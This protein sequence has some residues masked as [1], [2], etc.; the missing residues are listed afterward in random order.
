MT[1]A[2]AASDDGYLQGRLLIA[3][4]VIGDPRFDRSVVFM[5]AHGEDHAMGI[6]VNRPMGRLRLPELFEQLEVKCE[7]Q[8]PDRAVL[9]G[10]PVDRDRGFVL[11]SDDFRSDEGTLPVGEGIGLTATKEI[12]EAMASSR[13]P[14]RSTLAL[15]YA[16]WE[17]GQL[18]EEI[19]ANAWLVAEAD[20]ELV[21]GEDYDAKWTKALRKLGVTPEF[22]T[23]A[24][25]RA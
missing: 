22:L 17:A 8:V 6:I 3:S 10:G 18:E 19:Q 15:G 14:Q 9:D 13:A 5:C 4:P 7:I 11:H 2:P 1:D 23:G 16:G 24:S 12:L 21:F 20:D 25:G